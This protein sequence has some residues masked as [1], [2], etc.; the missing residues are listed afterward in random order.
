[1]ILLSKENVVPMN[2]L[3][4]LMPDEQ[5]NLIWI[6]S[7]ECLKLQISRTASNLMDKFKLQIIL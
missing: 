1:M 7:N 3:T 5:V 4:R 6:I 2:I